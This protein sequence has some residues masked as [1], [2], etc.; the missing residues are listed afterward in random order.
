[1]LAYFDCFAGVAGDMTLAALI[2]LGLEEEYLRD[3][4]SRLGLSGYSIDIRRS[5]RRGLAGVRF[6]VDVSEPQPHRSYETISGIIQR[7]PIDEA[8]KKLALDMFHVL[9][10]AE[11]R[12]HGVP[13]DAVHFHE[14]GAVDSIIDIVGTA[15]GIVALSI[16]R[17]IS[18]PLPLSRTFVQSAH[19]RIPSPA[20]A[21]LEVLN[22]VPVTGADSD[23]EM[24]TPTG[25]AI[26]RTLASDFGSYPRF[27]P[28]RTGYGLGSSDP[29]DRPN[30]LRIVLGTEM[31]DSILHDQVG[32]IECQVDDLDPRV[33]GDLMD[34]LLKKGALDVTFSPVQMKKNR[35]GTLVQ[36]LV[37][38][39]LITETCRLLLSH[40]TSL[41]ARVTVS[42]RYVLPRKSEVV[43]TTLGQVR[44][45]VVE[46]PQGEVERRPEFDD[47]R[48][49]AERAGRPVRDI[50]QILDRE[51]NR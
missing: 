6:E 7:A 49:I 4:I 20:P 10:Q 9:A 28:E 22:G 47:A 26:I 14:V 30:A 44:V 50:L 15:A 29:E 8:A 46:L 17:I 35:P 42:E 32:V 45:K 3:V 43:S 31:P 5:K 40:T 24:V 25:A 39:H 13:V 11:A 12:V 21:T 38:P 16:D 2:D 34:R 18:S 36:S 27:I 33:L 51:L 37:P 23:I 1:M 41:G 48:E 19:G